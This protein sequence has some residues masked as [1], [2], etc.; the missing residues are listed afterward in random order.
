[1]ATNLLRLSEDASLALHAMAL[2]AA[3]P[4]KRFSNAE[5]AH[6]FGA[7]EHTLAKVLQRLSRVGLLASVRGPHG[8][9]VLGK[10]PGEITLLEVYEAVEGP[11][12][13]ASCLLGTPVCKGRACVLGGLVQSIHREVAD[14]FAQTTLAEIAARVQFEDKGQTDVV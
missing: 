2:L 5:I 13:P 7:S 12:G 6:T 8:G 11:L 10:T 9:F 4:E 14:Y 1:M 3:H